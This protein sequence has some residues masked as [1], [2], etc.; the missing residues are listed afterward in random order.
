MSQ[1]PLAPEPD[2]SALDR[3]FA[4]ESSSDEAAAI[5]QW[6]ADHPDDRVILDALRERMAEPNGPL[7]AYNH[8][9]RV[10]AIVDYSIRAERRNRLRHQ[11]NGELATTRT[12][13]RWVAAALA[14][15]AALVLA[16]GYEKYG[17][18]GNG[19]DAVLSAA[20]YATRPGQR[21][22]VRLADGTTVL[23]APASHL[24]VRAVG[25]TVRHV[26]LKGEGYFTVRHQ[27]ATPFVVQA[28]NGIVRVLGTEFAVRRYAEDSTVRVA[29]ASG[30]VSVRARSDNA[31]TAVVLGASDAAQLGPRNRMVVT[32]H[33][34]LDGYLAWRTGQ[35]RFQDTP[36]SAILRELNRTYDLD[37]STTD[38]AIANRLITLTLHETTSNGV[39]DLLSQ[40]LD[41]DV[42]RQGRHVTLTRRSHVE[43]SRQQ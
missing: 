27:S 7:A 40:L 4:G 24:S 10:A 42:Q 43:T 20:E 31:A 6:L 33:I 36:V 16:V 2:P 38:T 23:L 19:G 30:R 18:S 28:G 3:Y 25:N 8:E 9:V 26:T 39:L 34:D 29:V 35:L 1:S 12:R 32:R 5:E 41:A 37:I 13:H 17:R 14:A 15:A 21:A 22:S 11:A